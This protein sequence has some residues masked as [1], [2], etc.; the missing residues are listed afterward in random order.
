MQ[1]TTLHELGTAALDRKAV[2]VPGHPVFSKPHKA[3][4]VAAFRARHI[5]PL[6]KQG[7]FIYEPKN[8]RL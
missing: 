7:M 8:K 6:I 1:I 5:H 2:V 4:W 3:S